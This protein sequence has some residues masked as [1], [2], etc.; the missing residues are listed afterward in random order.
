MNWTATVQSDDAQHG[1][2]SGRIWNTLSRAPLDAL[3]S[4]LPLWRG[5]LDRQSPSYSSAFVI[6]DDN[7]FDG[8]PAVV[9]VHNVPRVSHRKRASVAADIPNGDVTFAR[10]LLSNMRAS[11][12]F[13][14]RIAHPSASYSSIRGAFLDA[15]AGMFYAYNHLINSVCLS[16]A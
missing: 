4:I 14:T 12:N 9:L 11:A 13:N 15:G 7:L 5:A 10:R 16:H 3:Q 1:E 6:R 8:V 2:I